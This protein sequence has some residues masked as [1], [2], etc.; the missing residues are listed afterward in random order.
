MPKI[1]QNNREPLDTPRNSHDALIWQWIDTLDQNQ[2]GIR[3]FE[4]VVVTN[5]DVNQFDAR[6]AV[7]KISAAPPR[8]GSSGSIEFRAGDH[9]PQR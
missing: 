3:L 2:L 7:D 1:T 6:K 5:D 8:K 4:V 9:F